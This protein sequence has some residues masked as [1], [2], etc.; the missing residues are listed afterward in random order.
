[1]ETVKYKVSYVKPHR[2]FIDFEAVFPVNG[3]SLTLQLPAWRPGRYELG[4]FAKNI[5]K[6]EAIDPNGKPLPF[7]KVS[8]DSWRIE[9][10]ETPTV[11]IRYNYY[12][13]ELNA[14]STW[15]DENQLYI[16]PVN[17]FLYD[18]DNVSASYEVQLELPENYEIACGLETIGKH[19]LRARNMQQMM[20]CPFIASASLWH[21]TY[22]VQGVVYHIWIQGRHALDEKR[23]MDEFEAFTVSQVNRFGSIPCENY[24]F[25][26]QFPDQY[27]RHGVEHENSTVIAL[28][29]AERLQTK[30]GYEELLGISCHELY[31]TW[32]IKSIRPAEMMPYDFSKENYSKLG[33]VAEGVTTYYGDLFLKRSKVFSTEEYLLTLEDQI[34]RHLHNAGRFNLSVADSSFDTWLD[35]YSL[36]IPHRKVS[37]YTEGCLCAFITDVAIME[38]TDGEKSLDDVMVLM[39]NRFGKTGIGYTESD[40]RKAVEECAGKSLGWIFDDLIYGVEDYQPHIEHALGLLG[41]NLR[42]QTRN[43]FTQLTGAQVISKDGKVVVHSVWPDSPAD[44]AGMSKGDEILF[45]NGIRADE[46]LQAHMSM[47]RFSQV[48]TTVL[49]NRQQ[50]TL[51]L[52]NDDLSYFPIPSLEVEKRTSLQE[53]WWAK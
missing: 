22:E 3:E 6:W 31:H 19:T 20:D 53:K 40:Y 51:M 36:G 41:I 27:A 7:Q 17:C 42:Y 37:I 10:I 15:L 47:V 12:S 14:G 23:L 46:L 24:H 30:A 11:I 32:N 4:N 33:Y 49:R 29:P 21:R 35:G 25:L 5:Q 1:M 28:G 26:F 38:A 9:G 44:N 39:N 16:N 50:H 45:V 2:Q 13:A 52:V 34:K 43:S 48:S 18:P 8:K